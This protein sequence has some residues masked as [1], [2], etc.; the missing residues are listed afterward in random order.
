MGIHYILLTLR[1]ERDA[2][3]IVDDKITKLCHVR[4]YSEALR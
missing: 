1:F 4:R 2:N 3:G